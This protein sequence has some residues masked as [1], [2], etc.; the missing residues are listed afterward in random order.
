MDVDARAVLLRFFGGLTDPRAANR[1]H[2]LHDLLIL[3]VLGLLCRCDDFEEIVAW[4][5]AHE[6][7]LRTFLDLPHGIPSPDTFERVFA[8]LDPAALEARL[9][10]WTTALQQAAGDRLVQV[11]G[12]SLRRAFQTAGRKTLPHLVSAWSQA[13]HLVLA[14]VATAQKSNEITAIPELLALLDL[15]Q[16]TVSIDAIGCQKKIAQA[17]LDREGDYLLAVKA[18]QRDLHEAVRFF[19]TEAI[20]QGWEGLPHVQTQTTDSD[21]GRLEIRRCWA[22]HQVAWLKTQDQDWPGLQGLVCVECD[23]LVFGGTHSV[24]RRYFITSHDPRQVGAEFLL[25]AVRG[26]WSVENQLHWCLD[27]VF[28]EDDSRVRKGH[29]GENLSRMR[30]LALHLLRKLPGPKRAS[31]KT[32]RLLCSWKPDY[33]LKALLPLG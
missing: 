6:L 31:L 21:H 3:T 20:A 15:Q 24:E 4:G 7:W 23:R 30:R 8:R 32:K 16:A 33:L 28:R 14:Q 19:F 12:K 18:N 22:T 29:A 25:E 11:D 13:D 5:H 1:R 26:H 9:G 2:L 17:I 27:V 10:R